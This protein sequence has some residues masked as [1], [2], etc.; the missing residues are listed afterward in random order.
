MIID[1]HFHTEGFSPCS[2]IPL[3]KGVECARERG[4]DG[5][6][7][8]EHDVLHRGSDIRGLERRY[9]IKIIIGVEILSREGDILCFGLEH[10]PAA[11]IS[12]SELTALLKAGGGASIAAHPFRN[13]NRGVGDLFAELRDLT[14]VEAFNGN[15]TTENNAKAQALALAKGIPIVGGSDSHSL[16]RIGCF[17]TEFPGAIASAGELCKV[18]QS[19]DFGPVR[20]AG[21]RFENIVS[22]TFQRSC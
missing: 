13:N 12:A 7:I 3:E 19:G 10:I 2:R 20:L 9:G 18:L 15:T 21:D 1:L 5:I 8:T 4:L 11:G 22:D 6:C 16:E 14:A 17:A